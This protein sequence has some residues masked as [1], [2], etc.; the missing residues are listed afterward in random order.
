MRELAPCKHLGRRHRVHAQPHGL[1][2]GRHGSPNLGDDEFAL[3]HAARGGPRAAR[4]I[5][6]GVSH[7]APLQTHLVHVGQLRHPRHHRTAG[8]RALSGPYRTD[9]TWGRSLDEAAPTEKPTQLCHPDGARGGRR[10]PRPRVRS[11][12]RG[13]AGVGG[14]T[15][16]RWLGLCRQLLPPP[17]PKAVPG[18]AD[19][20]L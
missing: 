7:R 11:P 4:S 18:P 16:K 12:W 1:G 6:V 8:G 19:Q 9:R 17:A 15:R 20:R 2:L 13:R 5:V 14:G 3:R 10:T